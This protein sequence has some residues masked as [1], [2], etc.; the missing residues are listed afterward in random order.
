MITHVHYHGTCVIFISFYKEAHKNEPNIRERLI[1]FTAST[2]D[3]H[4]A[5]IKENDL[6]NLKKP[7]GVDV[8]KKAVHDMLHSPKHH[9]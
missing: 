5:F 1:F 3:T 6:R 9:A 4:L 8:L 7:L 2:D